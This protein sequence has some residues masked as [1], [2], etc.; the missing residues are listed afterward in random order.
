MLEHPT[1]LGPMGLVQFR[2][3]FSAIL[4]SITPDAPRIYFTVDIFQ[5]FTLGDC[6][7]I[8]QIRRVLLISFDQKTFHVS[9]LPV[10][11]TKDGPRRAS[12]RVPSWADFNLTVCRCSREALSFICCEHLRQQNFLDWMRTESE[13]KGR[14]SICNPLLLNAF[15]I[16]PCSWWTDEGWLQETAREFLSVTFFSG[17]VEISQ[18]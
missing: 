14:V 11:R 2:T 15:Y 3:V 7:Q 1:R 6:V 5:H 8:P 16:F 13:H 17:L 4:M 18:S 10:L 9:C 12:H